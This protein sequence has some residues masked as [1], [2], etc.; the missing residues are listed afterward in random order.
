MTDH[1][2]GFGVSGDIITLSFSVVADADVG[3]LV[4]EPGAL[5]GDGKVIAAK[6]IEVYIAKIWEQ[7][8]LGRKQSSKI[9]V[10][11][12][13]VKDDRQLLKDRYRR[14]FKHWRQFAKPT[15]YYCP[16]NVRL[17]GSA[18]TRLGDHVPKQIWISIRVPADTAPGIYKGR[19]TVKT[20]KPSLQ[21]S[22]AI[23][24][25][26]L[27][28]RL[29]EPKQD[30][31]I[32]YR[33]TLDVTRPQFYVS[34]ALLKRQLQDIFDHGFR[35]ITIDEHDPLLSKSV[36][37]LCE[38]IGFD[39]HL[40]LLSPHFLDSLKCDKL[41]PVLQVSDELDLQSQYDSKAA[42]WH[43]RN[44][45]LAKAHN[46]KTMATLFSA[47]FAA[48][49]LNGTIIGCAPDMVLY[50][51]STNRKFFEIQ[52]Q[53]EIRSHSQYYYWNSHM[54][55]PDLH[56][57]LAG[58]YLWKSGA[59]G[60]APYCYQHLPQ[61]PFSPYDDFDEWEPGCNKSEPYVALRDHCTVYPAK[62]GFIP[63]V[64][65]EGMRE[66]IIDLKYLTTL[67]ELLDKARGIA[68]I[69]L[70]VEQIERSVVAF[71][72]RIDLSQIIV[73]SETEANPFPAINSEDFHTFREQMARDIIRLTKVI[74]NSHAEN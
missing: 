41:T 35:S 58:V 49:F 14:G 8:G 2:R 67:H 9:L 63:T 27:E 54:E 25:D 19:L 48:Q 7:A 40:V 16:P 59:D 36:I 68:H 38:E 46:I 13:L 29:S 31:M 10:R 74:G 17:S 72:D 45:Q 57:A 1:V 39:R 69:Q 32:F 5:R 28:I 70:I 26:I 51:I 43:Q 65:W 20:R 73:N 66:G 71:L 4:F 52:S 42:F 60:I 6:A 55:K 21:T 56:R 15:M 23:E 11:E 24:I 3:D 30:L 37:E 61:F 47:S 33:G 53:S 12:L 62:D 18:R 64:Q 50:N 44:H 34:P 22:I